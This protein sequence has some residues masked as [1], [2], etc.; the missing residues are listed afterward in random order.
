MTKQ[1]RRLLSCLAILLSVFFLS[2]QG[3]AATEITNVRHWAAP[4]HTRVVFDLSADPNYQ[5]KITENTLTLEFSGAS[6]HSSL[7]AEKV[8]DKPGISKILFQSTG[9]DKCIITIVLGP[10]IKAEVFKLKKFMEKPDRVVVDIIVGQAAVKEEIPQE[11]VR[12]PSVKRRVIVID[13][14]HGG[15]DPGAIGQNGTYEKHVV[16]AIGRDIK[17]AIDRMPGYRAVLTRDGDYYVSFSRRLN[18]ARKTNAHLF[19]SVHAD[20]A[21][22][23]QARGSSV[24]CLSTGAASNEA[25][26]LL[27]NN[28][29]LSDI[30]GGVPEGEGNNQSGEIILNMFQTNTINL[31]K[32]YASHLLD[33]LGRVHCLKYPQFHEAPFRVLKLLDIPAVLLETAFLS[34]DEEERL[35]KTSKFRKTIASAVALSVSEYFSSASPAV[36]TAD[37]D[38]TQDRTIEPGSKK[39]LEA[40]RPA[41]KTITYRVKPGDNLN[42]IARKHETTLAVLLKLNNIK[43]DDPLYVGRKILV[44]SGAPE[45]VARKS[46]KRYTVKK[47]DTMFSLAKSCSVT[48]EEL[49]RINNMS[50]A[51]SLLL[52]QKIKLPQ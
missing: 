46:L 30:I 7:P 20:A 12:V 50:D 13:P 14:G 25:A 11:P 33:Q 40:K 42:T 35:L 8:I 9:R 10:H 29:N 21:R 19:I 32:T 15:E 39:A 45:P 3:F 36:L 16:L 44:P 6:L 23:R 24:Y 48:V 49:R 27:A 43:I 4:D 2:A 38:K 52:G 34:H 28:E 31:S 1:M 17:K 18:V 47:G 22:N 41:E 26:K 5:F 37:A 51:D